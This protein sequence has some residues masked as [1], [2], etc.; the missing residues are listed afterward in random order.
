MRVDDVIDKLVE[1]FRDEPAL[2]EV[3]TYHKVNGILPDIGAS[4]SIGCDKVKYSDYSNTKDEAEADINIFLYTQE[5]DP[6]FGEK[7][8]RTLAEN[9]RWTLTEDQTLDGLLSSGIVEEIEYIYADA[10]ETMVLHAAVIHYKAVFYQERRRPKE[11]T[12]P[13]G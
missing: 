2:A 11:S 6:E 5:A 10:G 8:V 9:A 1:R 12:A 7:A 13:V 3:F 4:L